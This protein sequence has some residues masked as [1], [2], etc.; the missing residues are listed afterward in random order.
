MSSAC[1]QLDD[2]RADG[3]PRELSSRDLDLTT[4]V[5]E[6]LSALDTAASEL[7]HELAAVRVE[8]RQTAEKA[9]ETVTMIQAAAESALQ[10]ARLKREMEVAE[11]RAEVERLRADL[12]TR[13]ELMDGASLP[14]AD[15]A[16]AASASDASGETQGSSEL[17][18]SQIAALR[19]E[20]ATCREES[21]ELSRRLD[22][23]RVKHERFVAAVR[24]LQVNQA[25]PL[26]CEMSLMVGGIP[27]HTD[28][29]GAVFAADDAEG[30]SGA[31]ESVEASI[32]EC[33][34]QDAPADA[35]NPAHYA[36]TL[37][38]EIEAVYDADLASGMGF[39]ELVDR[40]IDNLR[41]AGDMFVRRGGSL[42]EHTAGFLDRVAAT[43]DE[44]AGTMF[45]RHLAIA[46]FEYERA[47]ASARVA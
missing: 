26:A 41:Y 24:S 25:V 39:Q 27:V 22:D 44:K 12:R 38:T 16:T 30:D 13:S 4:A 46:A 33:I 28:A 9:N 19:H 1:T 37:L 11:L 5:K 45:A 10:R 14:G 43:L 32:A 3:N 20:L 35:F 40:L 2:D 7:V 17:Y 34:Q 18:Q 21:A 36:Q 42:V 31:L 29:S 8:S 15:A 23:Q 6:A 47:D